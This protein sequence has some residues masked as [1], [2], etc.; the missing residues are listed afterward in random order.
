MRESD[1]RCRVDELSLHLGLDA[2]RSATGPEPVLQGRCQ[3]LVRQVRAI[4][5]W[6]AAMAQRERLVAGMSMS[7]EERVDA[8]R[9]LAV[10][11]RVH[12]A[13]ID[14]TR[15]ALAADV[16]PMT[17]AGPVT[18]VLA[19]RHAWT[20]DRL[21]AAL[22][23][24]GVEILL[25]TDSGAEALGA[26][27]AEQ[28]DVLFT[29]ERL[30]MLSGRELLSEAGLFAPFT[31]LAVQAADVAAERDLLGAEAQVVVPHRR[32]AAEVADLLAAVVEQRAV[33][34]G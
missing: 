30:L 11:R 1:T 9:R 34:A 22:R 27:V 28:P 8:A 19:H 13:V 23:E 7:R 32:Q 18:A 21:A 16:T 17:S 2:S 10:L 33:L 12:E 14:R 4:E 25:C 20:L 29:G 24:R 3:L 5:A 31:L 26:V 6:T 15:K